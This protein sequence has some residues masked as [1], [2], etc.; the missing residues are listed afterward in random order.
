MPV[1]NEGPKVVGAIQKAVKMFDSLLFSSFEIIVVDDGSTDD[2]LSALK[3]IK[4][5][6]I[7]VVGYPVNSGKGAAQ[8]FAFGF[9]RG[10]TIIFADG[11]AQAFPDDLERY[12]NALNHADIAI[13]SKRVPGAR[14]N[15]SVM[16][17]F[18]SIGFNS[19][20][21]ILLSLPINDTQA[22]FK[23]FRRSALAEILPLISVKHYA[24]DVELLVV[25]KKVCNCNIAELPATVTLTSGFS[26]R[27]I[28]R[29]LLDILGIGYRLRIKHWYQD[30]YRSE[31]EQYAPLLRW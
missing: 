19:L 6:R 10:D 22:G 11:D 23:V 20:V 24:F 8:I 16:R 14:V 21:R 13:A 17:E 12:I 1:Y 28:M 26:L 5:E 15:A 9:A 31:H 4:D 25:G 3:T 27:H 30:N 7:V 29:M 2:T 18:L